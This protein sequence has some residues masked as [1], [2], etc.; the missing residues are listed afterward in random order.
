MEAQRLRQRYDHRLQRLVHDTGDIQLALRNGVPRSTA[1]DWSR[2]PSKDVVT[3]DVYSMSESALQQE[4]VGLRARNAKLVAMLRLVVVLLRVCDVTLAR[5]R[6]S[7]GD[8]KRRILRAVERSRAAIPLRAAL[9]LLGLS[10]SRY[11]S[12]RRDEECTLDDVSS[13]PQSRPQQI[14]TDEREAIREMVC[15]KEY[16]H[17]PTGRLAIF[18]Q[19]LGKVFASPSTWHRLVRKHRWRRPRKRVHP[20][21]PRVGIRAIRPNE[22]W[23]I[24]TTVVRLL[25]GTHAY[26]YAVIDNFSRRILAWRVSEHF[27]PTMTLE[28]LVEAG[29]A[30]ARTDEPPTVFTDAGVENRTAAIDELIN[31]G[32]LR[33]V[34]AQTEIAFSNSMIESWWRTLKHQW[35][36]LNTLDTVESLRRLVD[37]YVREHNTQ[38]PHSAFKGQTPDEMYR[39]TGKHV[40]EE[41]AERRKTARAERLAAN[42]S[43]S[44]GVCEAEAA[45]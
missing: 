15:S 13:C 25:D 11:H 9:R 12:W 40:P 30:T 16:R 4:V 5:R 45:V 3:L 17:V 29:K 6:I 41:L 21:K 14:T 22:I 19:R 27:D 20:P 10:A 42:R 33:R 8:K 39:G 31:S 35:L 38:L 28:V 1:R 7:D 32:I 36:Y 44:C 43:V 26:L 37:F 2:L 18:A 23:H 34:L 24:D